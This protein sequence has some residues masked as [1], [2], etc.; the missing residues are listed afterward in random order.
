MPAAR[1]VP[2]A[3][4]VFEIYNQIVFGRRLH[5]HITWFLALENAVDISRSTTDRLVR[6]RPINNQ[7]TVCGIIT[8]RVNG[9][10]RS[11]TRP[12]L[13]WI[14]TSDELPNHLR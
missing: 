14:L 5:R 3:L 7:A 4:A 12:R 9:R 11:C 13:I 6:I 10:P 2:S 1:R 8:V